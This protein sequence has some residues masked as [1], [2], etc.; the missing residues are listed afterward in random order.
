[1][2]GVAPSSTEP[3][4][5]EALPGGGLS[6][7]LSCGTFSSEVD[8]EGASR[9]ELRALVSAVTSLITAAGDHGVLPKLTQRL[10]WLESGLVLRGNS[11]PG[12]NLNPTVRF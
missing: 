2:T 8:V 9:I 6:V 5:K 10:S 7:R 1:M 12:S 11:N 4:N 3:L